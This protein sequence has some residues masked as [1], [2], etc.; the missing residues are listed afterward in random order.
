MAENAVFLDVESW[1]SRE[2]EGCLEFMSRS[3]RVG[4]WGPGG[5]SSS[6]FWPGIFCESPSLRRSRSP[7]VSSDYPLPLYLN[8]YLALAGIIRAF[9]FFCHLLDGSLYATENGLELT[10]LLLQ[11][12]EC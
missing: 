7:F 11:P 2:F 10:I 9:Y 6:K 5:S 1:R 8:A 12:L 3:T 4:S